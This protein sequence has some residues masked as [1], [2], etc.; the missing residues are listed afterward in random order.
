M[1]AEWQARQMSDGFSDPHRG[2]NRTLRDSMSVPQ[3]VFLPRAEIAGNA[4]IFSPRWTMLVAKA[5]AD[6]CRIGGRIH[7]RTGQQ[8]EQD[9]RPVARYN[10]SSAVKD[11]AL[12]A[13]N[14]GLYETHARQA[15]FVERAD[16]NIIA[17]DVAK[18]DVTSLQAAGEV[19]EH[20]LVRKMG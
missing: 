11:F 12:A 7:M 13:L 4:A 9:Y 3:L 18:L 8:F 15:R 1:P 14:V 17:L 6:R 2:K 19:E 20:P 10:Y 5:L 16:F